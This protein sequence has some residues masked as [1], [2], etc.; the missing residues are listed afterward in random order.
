MGTYTTTLIKRELIATET[1]KYT[2]VCP[3]DFIFVAGQYVILEILNP[4]F[5]D[6]R[7]AFRSLSIASAPSEGSLSFIMRHS[8]S[9][10]KKSLNALAMGDEI[11][12]KGPL[13]HFVLPVDVSQPVVFL[14]AGVGITP[15]RS[16][17]KQSE[18]E[19]CARPLTLLYSNREVASAACKDELS[20]IGLVNYACFNT[21][22]DEVQGW[23]GHTG[24]ID[25]EMIKSAVD[26]ITKPLYYIVGTKGFIEG[27]KG[28]LTELGIAKDRMVIDNFG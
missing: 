17:I 21:I 20:R 26:D 27:M 14:T 24:F 4:A 25:A 18:F 5:T 16:M 8:E 28:T 9:A 7:P 3:R 2:F 22:T 10:F 13:G 15:A 12:I 6:E 1:W 19:G 23:N 11:M